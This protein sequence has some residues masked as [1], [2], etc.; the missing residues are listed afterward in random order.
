MVTSAFVFA[1]TAALRRVHLTYLVHA[2]DLF[3][4][5]LPAVLQKRSKSFV[6]GLALPI[7]Q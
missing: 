4:N 7:W 1:K 6:N 2:A 3:L 5:K